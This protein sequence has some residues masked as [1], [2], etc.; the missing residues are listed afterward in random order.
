[1]SYLHVIFKLYRDKHRSS[2]DGRL[3]REDIAALFGCLGRKAST[4][5]VRV[6][7]ATRIRAT[8]LP[9]ILAT[10][11]HAFSSVAETSSP[12]RACSAVASAL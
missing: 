11:R 5:V 10:S 4:Y 1:M 7:E 9:T 8:L 2:T 6:R 12:I 3:A